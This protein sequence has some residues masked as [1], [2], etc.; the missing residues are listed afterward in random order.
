MDPGTQMAKVDIESVYRMVHDIWLHEQAY[1]ESPLFM[2]GKAS[3]ALSRCLP[4][5]YLPTENADY[6]MLVNEWAWL[7]SKVCSLSLKVYLHGFS[8]GVRAQTEMWCTKG[9]C[10]LK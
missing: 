2:A 8:F 9:M 10:M 3:W 1:S 5:R 6:R 7:R 4:S